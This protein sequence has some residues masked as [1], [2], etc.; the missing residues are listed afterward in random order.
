MTFQSPMLVSFSVLHASILSE[1]E[2]R[3]GLPFVTS[4]L[5]LVLLA[6]RDTK[7]QLVGGEHLSTIELHFSIS[8]KWRS[9]KELNPDLTADDVGFLCHTRESN[10]NA[11]VHGSAVWPTNEPLP[12]FLLSD[13]LRRNVHFTIPSLSRVFES[14][15]PYSW[16]TNREYGLRLSSICFSAMQG[17]VPAW[18]QLDETLR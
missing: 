14:E 10:G 8:S 5:N 11:F 18:E 9:P 1:I 15:P 3:S 12:Q 16:G 6:D 17:E 2:M 7:I 4:S 13:N